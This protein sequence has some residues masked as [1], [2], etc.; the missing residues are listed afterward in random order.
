MVAAAGLTTVHVD[1]FDNYQLL[2]CDGE[3]EQ[4]V[5]VILRAHFTQA[6][7]EEMTAR[8][9]GASKPHVL[10]IL[11]SLAAAAMRRSGGEAAYQS[12]MSE[13]PAPLQATYEN[14]WKAK[15]E[16]DIAYINALTVDSDVE[17]PTSSDL[18]SH[19]ATAM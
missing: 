6:E 9:I 14:V 16:A 2:R 18:G 19:V 5:P 15:H 4:N 1:V 17:P 8:I 11:F 13:S 3:E 12:F 10:P 7:D